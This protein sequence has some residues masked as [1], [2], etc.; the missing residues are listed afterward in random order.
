MTKTLP[1]LSFA[2]SLLFI[3]VDDNT[4]ACNYYCTVWAKVYH[5]HCTPPTGPL[6]SPSVPLQCPSFVN[7]VRQPNKKQQEYHTRGRYSPVFTIFPSSSFLRQKNAHPFQRY[8]PFEKTLLTL[9]TTSNN[10]N[11]NS[12]NN[13]KRPI[14]STSSTLKQK[15]EDAKEV[16]N[17]VR[18]MNSLEI[19]GGTHL[20]GIS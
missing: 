17:K 3:N 10:N 15:T 7:K 19:C 14:D 9:Y 6:L 16:I 13:N 5:H 1:L 2:L 11:H 18:N 20:W 4:G 8:S 12:N